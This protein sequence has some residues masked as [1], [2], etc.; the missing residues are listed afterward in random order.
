MKLIAKLSLHRDHAV[1]QSHDP[2]CWGVPIAQ[3]K[4]KSASGLA[5][6]DPATHTLL[7]VQADITARWPDGSVKWLFITAINVG[8]LFQRRAADAEIPEKINVELCQIDSAPPFSSTLKIESRGPDLFAIDTGVL[9]FE[10]S[11][12]GPLIPRFDALTQGR[13]LTLAAGLDLTTAAERDGRLTEY[14]ASRSPRKIT[15]ESSGPARAC[16]LIQGTHAEVNGQTFAPYSLRLVVIAGLARVALTHSIIFDGDPDRDFLRESKITLDTRAGE[17]PLF[18]FGGDAG[19]ESRFVRQHET[20]LADWRVAELYQDS[21]SHWRIQRHVEPTLPGVFGDEGNRSDGWAQITGGRGNVAL[22]VRDFA[23]NHPKTLRVD[24]A[25]GELSA[26][27]YPRRA[28]RLDLRRYSPQIYVMSYEAPCTWKHETLPFPKHCN[29]LGVRKTHDLLLTFNDANPS[30]TTDAFNHPLRLSWAPAYTAKTGIVVPAAKKCDSRWKKIA[31]NYVT[32]MRESLVRGGASGYANYFDLPMGFNL[33][34]QRWMHE[35]GG[36]A[37]INNEALPC[38]GL[39]QTYLLTGNRDALTLARAMARHNSD[40]DTHYLG[41]FAGCG[42]R[43]NVNHWGDACKEPRISQPIDKRLSYFLTGD[44]SMLD[45][46]RVM[47]DLFERTW[48]NDRWP[49]MVAEVP[50]FLSTAIF[51]SD[52]GLISEDAWLIR[53]ADALADSI[54]ENGRMNDSMMVNYPDRKAAAAA[55]SRK[56]NYNMFS[57]FGAP[58]IF[59]ELAE[60]YR[61]Q[62]LRDALVRMARYQMLPR[63]R[64]MELEPESGESVLADSYVVFRALDLLGYGYQLTGDRAIADYVE[65]HTKQPHVSIEAV[66]ERRYGIA[67]GGTRQVP[68]EHEWHDDPGRFKELVKHYRPVPGTHTAQMFNMAVYLHK[69]QGIMLLANK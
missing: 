47:L 61:H 10:V 9:R 52:L 17:P 35:H 1:A 6:R 50:A 14:A 57:C 41:T 37:Y 12:T 64:R 39:F 20:F 18:G 40:S 31:E 22:A 16:I 24:G 32:F 60:R 43:H 46:V 25:S 67:N 23:E 45:L 33:I 54:D 42:S 51:A 44:A 58:Q 66:D 65:F 30:A 63:A 62:K 38:L 34:D 56:L 55:N 2:L 13:W 8:E 3:K 19:R 53:I 68:V 36:M 21:I 59:P 28:D 4:L 49:N 11:P 26:G 48:A 15:L 5:L 27:L 69:L 29:A 7:P